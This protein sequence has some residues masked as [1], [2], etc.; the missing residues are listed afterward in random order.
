MASV[1]KLL[2]LSALL[3]CTKALK[4]ACPKTHHDE[5]LKPKC[6]AVNGC[7]WSTTSGCRDWAD[8]TFCEQVSKENCDKE[9]IYH[10][11]GTAR[12]VWEKRWDH[13]HGTIEGCWKKQ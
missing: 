5:S 4:K 3:A 11:E 12:C 6:L 10:G 8:Q 13:V 9:V 2:T 1:L 7:A